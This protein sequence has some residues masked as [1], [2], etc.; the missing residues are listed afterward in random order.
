MTSLCHRSVWALKSLIDKGELSPLELMLDTIDRIEKIDPQLNAFAALRLEEALEDARRMTEKLAAGESVG[1][2][3]GIPLGVKDL[4]DVADM[5]TSYGSVPFKGNIAMEDSIQ[6]A[7]LKA[8][9]AIVVGKTNVPEFGFTGFT[10]NR[11]HGITRNPWNLERTPG[12]SS[13][14]S[15]AA[16]AGGLVPLCTGSDA[17]GSIRIPAS[18][19]GCFG[20]KLS[21]GRIPM[22]PSP[23]VSYSGL[24]VAGPLSRTVRDAAM[25]LDV[26]VGAH[27]AD[28][29]SLPKPERSFLGSL[30]DLPEGL[31]IAYSPDLGY[32]HVQKEVESWAEKAALTF[33]EMGHI[34]EMWTGGLPDVADVWTPLICTDIYA[35]LGDVLDDCRD[36]M[37]RT[38]VGVVEHTRTL[39]VDNLTAFQKERAK[40]NKKLETFFKSF[41]LLLTPTMPTVAFGAGGPPPM[42][43]EGKKIPF[44]GAVA[45]T[46]PFNLS[47][48]PAASVPAGITVEGLPVGL[49]IIGPR[50]QDCLVMQAARAYEK[51]RPWNNCWPEL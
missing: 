35:Q 9:G 22:G 21:L 40:L 47:G 5:I 32:A 3:A 28:P 20:V 30:D 10:K 14:G 13:G 42:E 39:T 50:L 18:Y 11:L 37:G 15:A 1:P 16:I 48:N 17:G 51:I 6:V 25:Y 29:F 45:F 27:P 4:E 41:D 23:F 8:A 33:E 38:L 7:R 2:L 12:G 19:C 49:Q 43:I 24:T 44:L 46:Y 31:R 26:T 36:E 34:V